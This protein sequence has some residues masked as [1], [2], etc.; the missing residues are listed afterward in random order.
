[1][2]D[3]TWMSSI[4]TRLNCIRYV[5]QHGRICLEQR[6]CLQILVKLHSEWGNLNPTLFDIRDFHYKTTATQPHCGGLSFFIENRQ[7]WSICLCD[8]FMCRLLCLVYAQLSRK[9]ITR[10][11]CNATDRFVIASKRTRWNSRMLSFFLW[12]PASMVETSN[13]MNLY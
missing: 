1:M 4:F 2:Y 6:L 11:P 9:H 7:I 3:F 10:D 13:F 8:E 5:K 12:A